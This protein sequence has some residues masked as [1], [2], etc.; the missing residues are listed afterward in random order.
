MVEHMRHIL[1]VCISQM[2]TEEASVYLCPAKKA[3]YTQFLQPKKMD[4]R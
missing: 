4:E 2:D 1:H 3:A